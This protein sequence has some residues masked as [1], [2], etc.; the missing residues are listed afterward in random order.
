MSGLGEGITVSE[1]AKMLV[2]IDRDARKRYEDGFVTP[3]G[4]FAAVARV[5]KGI[6][7]SIR[8]NRHH[9]REISLSSAAGHRPIPAELLRLTSEAHREAVGAALEVRYTEPRDF[10]ERGGQLMWVVMRSGP[11]NA[12]DRLV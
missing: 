3:E 7:I 5:L 9:Q 2:G 11:E 1:L 4:H 6:R 12:Q 10:Q 8:Y